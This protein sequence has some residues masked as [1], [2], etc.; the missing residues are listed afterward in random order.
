VFRR[1][2]KK[3]WKKEIL[4]NEYLMKRDKREGI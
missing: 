2:E 4:N 1:I 3:K